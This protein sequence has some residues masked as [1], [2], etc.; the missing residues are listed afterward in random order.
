MRN[1][2]CLHATQSLGGFN[3]NSTLPLPPP[4]NKFLPNRTALQPAAQRE[5][6]RQPEQA[7]SQLG[8]YDPILHLV[9]EDHSNLTLSPRHEMST[10]FSHSREKSKCVECH[11]KEIALQKRPG[12]HSARVSKPAARV[13]FVRCPI[14]LLA[15]GPAQSSSGKEWESRLHRE[16]VRFK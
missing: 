1:A 16:Q 14:S 12:A 3:T 15:A 11:R 7:R 8:R 6:R 5:G 13:G 4:W 10:P 2:S 9:L